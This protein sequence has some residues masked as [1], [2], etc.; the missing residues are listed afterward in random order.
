[1]Q[2][3]KREEIVNVRT[4]MH[5][6]PVTANTRDGAHQ[7]FRRM[8]ERGIRH[9]PVLGD[10]GRLV[11]IVSDRDLRRPDTLDDDPNVVHPYLLDNHVKVEQIMTPDPVTVEVDDDVRRALDLLV[12]RRYGALPVI[13]QG[14]L[15]GIIS[16][17]DLLRAFRDHLLR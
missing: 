8:C 15:V 12:T 13:D 10:D 3:P 4:Y 11:G 9:M 1:M 6:E 16:T 7:T 14:R 17:V 2:P 5:P